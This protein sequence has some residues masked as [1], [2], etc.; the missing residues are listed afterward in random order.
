MICFPEH[1]TGVVAYVAGYG[2]PRRKMVAP[3]DRYLYLKDTETVTRLIEEVVFKDTHVLL[4]FVSNGQVIYNVIVP[5]TCLRTDIDAE[6][7]PL[8]EDLLDMEE[9]MEAGPEGE[10]ELM[11]VREWNYPAEEIS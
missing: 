11:D 1:I 9:M 3:L 5:E 10:S 2:D 4:Y 7:L 8:R 6:A